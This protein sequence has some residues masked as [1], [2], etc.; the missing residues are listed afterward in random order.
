MPF[1]R[2][3]AQVEYVGYAISQ[4]MYKLLPPVAKNNIAVHSEDR[5]HWA[6]KPKPGCP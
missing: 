5:F 4:C 2:M 3:V 1:W 6:Y